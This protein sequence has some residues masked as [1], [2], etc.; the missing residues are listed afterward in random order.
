V[1]L[2]AARKAKVPVAN[3]GGANSVAVSI[4]RMEAGQAPLWVVPELKSLLG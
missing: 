1:D 4:Q 3:N 2:E